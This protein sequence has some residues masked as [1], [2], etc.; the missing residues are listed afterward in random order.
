MAAGQAAPV[1]LKFGGTS[2]A[3]S[4]SR[5]RVVDRVREYADEGP[6]VVVVSAMG[7]SGSPYATDTLLALLDGLPDNAREAD[8]VAACGEIISAAVLAQ[9]LVAAGLPAASL[10]G[11]EAG[12]LTDDRH[13][14]ARVIGVDPTG[15]LSTLDRGVVPVVAGFQGIAPDGSLTTLGRGGSD[16][17][18][19][20]LAGAIDAST[21]VILSDVEG[22]MTADPTDLPEARVLPVM[23]YQELFHLARAGSRV[24]HAPAAEAAMKAGVPLRVRSTFSDAPGT[25]LTDAEGVSLAQA[26]RVAT[27]VSHVDGVSRFCVTLP[28]DDESGDHMEAQTRVYASMAQAG[29]SLDMFTPCRELLVFSTREVDVAIAAGTLERLGLPFDVEE[30]LAKVTL[31][32][33]GMHGVPGVMAK[34]AQALDAAGVTI[35]QVSDSHA[36]I[37]VLV[38]QDTRQRA[39]KALH[40]AFSLGE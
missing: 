5:A 14:D 8:R 37:S 3:D 2:V 1:V 34:L 20:V 4:R 29:V 19:C 31:V 15:V 7:R 32:G 9:T 25:L 28:P 16:T 38:C 13:G 30:G 10:S 39:V 17:T 21:V 18:A 12:I 6:V 33:A 35:R 26:P 24:V 22:V 40:E 36:T 27:A 23:E 11:A